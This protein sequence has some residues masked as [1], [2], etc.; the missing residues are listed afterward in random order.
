MNKYLDFEN[1]IENIEKLIADLD[2]SKDNFRSEKTK[3]LDKQ[4]KIFKKIYS[5]C[6]VFFHTLFFNNHYLSK[7]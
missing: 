7:L 3:L 5:I 6:Y 2:K 4:N 1:D